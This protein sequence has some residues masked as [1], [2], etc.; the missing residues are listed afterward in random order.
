MVNEE[1]E[2]APVGFHFETQR[3]KGMLIAGPVL[4]GV[5]Y[6]LSVF[7]GVFGYTFAGVTS[8]STTSFIVR[9]RSTYL[10]YAVPVA[11]PLLSQVLFA[12][13]SGYINNSSRTLELMFAGIVTILQATGVTLTVLGIPSRQVLVEDRRASKTSA[14]PPVHLSFAPF[15]TG[16]SFGFSLLLEH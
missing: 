12:T 16:S 2:K 4:F 9:N 11:G 13:A 3:R 10:V 15:A 14:P 8:S 1:G 5:G 6:I 7:Y